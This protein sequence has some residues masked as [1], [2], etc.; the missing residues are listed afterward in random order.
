MM[1]RG[2]LRMSADR[3]MNPSIFDPVYIARKGIAQGLK[4]AAQR[5][6]KGKLIDLGCGMKPYEDIFAP[7]CDSYFGVDYPDAAKLNYGEDTRADLW[8]DCTETGLDAE[9]FDTVLSTQVLEHIGHPQK[10]L[11]EAHRLLKKGGILIMTA[12]FLWQEHSIPHDYCRFS[13]YSLQSFV[14]EAGFDVL[15][16]RKLEGA[17]ASIQQMN[18]VSILGRERKWLLSKIYH[19]VVNRFI[20]IPLINVAA[21]TLDKKVH[22]DK[23]YLTT[24]TIAEKREVEE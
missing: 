7:Y 19:G 24:L 3:F 6:A 10:L 8:T 4:D 1:E 2:T 11:E 14:E 22:N 23:L 21:M 18:I 9:S 17:F 12:P 16:I 15:E 5:Y 20:M 13:Q